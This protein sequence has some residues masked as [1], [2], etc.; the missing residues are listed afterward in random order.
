M[1]IN[2][3]R[4]KLDQINIS[5]RNK[6]FYYRLYHTSMVIRTSKI[7]WCEHRKI[8]ELCLIIFQHHVRKG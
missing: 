5:S 7:F 6:E 2:T 4:E 3:Q 1:T 8:H